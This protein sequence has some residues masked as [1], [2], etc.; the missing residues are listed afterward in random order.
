MYLYT[1]LRCGPCKQIAPDYEKLSEKYKNA[2]FTKVDVDDCSDVAQDYSVRSMPTFVFIKNSKEIE[3]FSGA[4]IGQLESTISKNCSVEKF[5][6]SGYTLSGT[7]SSG[8]GLGSAP[9]QGGGG[10]GSW[11]GNAI[12]LGGGG[13]GVGQGLGAN[14]DMN[15]NCEKQAK[16]I[17]PVNAKLPVCQVSLRLADGSK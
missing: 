13:G 3:R 2:K 1:V 12:G 5:T 6:G 15:L 17:F 16:E 8:G 7:G 9:A 10:I 4:S 14:Q 11:L